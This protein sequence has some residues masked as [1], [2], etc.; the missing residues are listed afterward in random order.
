MAIGRVPQLSVSREILPWIG[1]CDTWDAAHY[2]EVRGALCPSMGRRARLRG[3]EEDRSIVVLR[4]GLPEGVPA[5]GAVERPEGGDHLGSGPCSA[6]PCS[7]LAFAH[8]Q[9]AGTLHGS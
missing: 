3:T 1:G 5:T 6:H 7:V 9:L 4:L 8:Q 2:C